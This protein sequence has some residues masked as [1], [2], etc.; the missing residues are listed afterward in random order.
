M[1]RS[2]PLV[3]H[4]LPVPK[5]FAG[6]RLH[7]AGPECLGEPWTCRQP[8]WPIIDTELRPWADA[9]VDVRQPAVAI[10]RGR[11][12]PNAESAPELG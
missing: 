2:D 7:Q 6:R 3:H 12:L 4:P 10:G 11:K 9:E 8:E 1:A 5:N